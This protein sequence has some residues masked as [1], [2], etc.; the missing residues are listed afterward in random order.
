MKKQRLN[1]GKLLVHSHTALGD[2]ISEL[3]DS[4]AWVLNHLLREITVVQLFLIIW[5]R[6]YISSQKLPVVQHHI[7]LRKP[8]VA[9]IT[10]PLLPPFHLRMFI[11]LNKPRIYPHYSIL[12]YLII[13]VKVFYWSFSVGLRWPSFSLSF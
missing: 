12:M 2:T 11:T 4:K 13:F 5:K 1:E 6:E 10:D 7:T 9:N 8:K 3:S